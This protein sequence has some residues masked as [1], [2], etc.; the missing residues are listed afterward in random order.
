[1]KWLTNGRAKTL[2]YNKHRID[3]DKPAP[4]KGAQALKDYFRANCP[5]DIWLEEMVI[6]G[7]ILRVDF[8]NLTKKVAIEFNGPQHSKFNKFF[9][10]NN[11]LNYLS[12]RKRDERK[13]AILIENGFLLAVIEAADLKNLGRQLFFEKIGREL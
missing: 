13:E 12:S 9:H 5:N 7:T 8:V 10:N 1:M 2:S 4:S 11:R 3:W 6:P